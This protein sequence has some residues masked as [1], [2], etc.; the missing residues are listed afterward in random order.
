MLV[1]LTDKNGEVL[2]VTP[3]VQYGV[4]GRWVF[5]SQSDRW[6]NEYYSVGADLA[7]RTD[8]SRWVGWAPRNRFWQ[9]II[10]IEQ[11]IQLIIWVIDNW[12]SSEDEGGP[13]TIRRSSRPIRRC[14][15][16]A[17]TWSPSVTPEA[18]PFRG[19]YADMT[20]S[21]QDSN[22]GAAVAGVV[23]KAMSLPLDRAGVPL[24]RP[25]RR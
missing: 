20:V 8:R 24:G 10:P 16:F 12:P 6:D 22:S 4:D 13:A 15:P 14:R 1:S 21:A 11:I 25:G 18:I 7:A 17:V 2:Y 9:D 5:W 3:L 19:A 23:Y